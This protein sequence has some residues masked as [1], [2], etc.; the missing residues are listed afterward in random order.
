MSLG[1]R[2]PVPPERSL[3]AREIATRLISA[4]EPESARIFQFD[5]VDLAPALGQMLFLAIRSLRMGSSTLG[6][7]APVGS[8]ARVAYA[9]TIRTGLRRPRVDGRVAAI[10]LNPAHAEILRPIAAAL[11]EAGGPSIVQVWDGGLRS[12]GGAWPLPAYAPLASLPRVMATY[13]RLSADLKNL[14][15]RWD[16]VAEEAVLSV[17]ATVLRRELR[18][19]ILDVA[20]LS[21]LAEQDPVLML[22]FDEIGRRARLV[23]PIAAR[24]GIPSLDLPHAEAADALA[25]RGA[26]YDM[27]GVFGPRAREV[28]QLAGIVPSRIRE[29]GPSRFDPLVR[30]D[31]TT[32][33]TPRRFVFASQWVGGQMTAAVKRATIEIAIQAASAAAPCELAIKPHPLERDRIADEVLSLGAPPGVSAFVERAQSLYG[34]LDGAWTLLTGW[35]NAAFEGV[36]AHVPII[37]INATGGELPTTFVEEGLALGATSVEDAVAVVTRLLDPA[38][39]DG[40]VAAAR[41][42]LA[43]HLGP[44]DG[45]AG[46][47]AAALI[48]EM[49]ARGAAGV[50]RRDGS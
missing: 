14:A 48:M 43:G 12:S 5:G 3:E 24:Y 13:R 39:R 23:G 42:L 45:R 8:L 16:G 32:P 9:R 7:P 25:I 41:S 2:A 36:L 49:A 34:L 40:V 26:A 20:C 22:T 29:I 44:L 4:L 35:S 38:V 18:R 31:P 19:A 6:R 33:V 37:C 1:I 46:E 50:E 21:A 11:A 17:A 10:T 28:L 30:R 15:E 47:R 27:F